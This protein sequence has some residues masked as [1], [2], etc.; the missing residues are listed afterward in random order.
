VSRRRFVALTLLIGVAT[1]VGYYAATVAQQR[2]NPPDCR[3][4]G[5]GC[6]PS[7]SES[8]GIVGILYVGPATVVLLVFGALVLGRLKSPQ[9]RTAIASALLAIAG[10]AGIALVLLFE[11]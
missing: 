1:V 6:S 5:G 2:R 11:G 3:G 4:L 9:S 7:P 8:V 10:V